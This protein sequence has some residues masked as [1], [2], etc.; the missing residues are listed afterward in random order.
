MEIE[1]LVLNNY[2][3]AQIKMGFQ[4]RKQ[5]LIVVVDRHHCTS[6]HDLMD[7]ICSACFLLWETIPP[8]TEEA[9]QGRGGGGEG[10]AG[11]RGDGR[12]DGSGDEWNGFLTHLLPVLRQKF[13]AKSRA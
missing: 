10:W 12:V 13:E 5:S 2:A 11:R 3:L 8:H 1:R 9:E 7:K 6:W 4:I